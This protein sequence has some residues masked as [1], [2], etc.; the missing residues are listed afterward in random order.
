MNCIW[1]ACQRHKLQ[2]KFLQRLVTCRDTQLKS[3]GFASLADLEKYAQNSISPVLYLL[4][5]AAGMY[6]SIDEQVLGERV[7]QTFCQ[8]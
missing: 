3:P 1:Q 2:P 4:L 8:A 6:L 5:Q 7:G